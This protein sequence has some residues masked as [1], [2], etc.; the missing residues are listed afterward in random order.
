[1]SRGVTTS[2]KMQMCGWLSEEMALASRSKRWRSV[3]SPA[4]EAG[5]AL[6]RRPVQARVARSMDLSHAAGAQ[7]RDDFVGSELGS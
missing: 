5:M 3:S 2:Y 4:S 6:M 1:L 7:R